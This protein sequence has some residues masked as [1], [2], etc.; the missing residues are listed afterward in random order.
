MFVFHV[1][2]LDLLIPQWLVSQVDHL[3][4]IQLAI[5]K[6]WLHKGPPRHRLQMISQAMVPR[7]DHLDMLIPQWLV[8]QVDHLVTIQLAIPKEMAP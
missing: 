4:P 1:E 7:V 8:S 6:R 3:V 5:P 2:H